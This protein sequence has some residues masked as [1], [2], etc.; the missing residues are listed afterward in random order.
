V[1]QNRIEKVGVA[2]FYGDLR[3]SWGQNELHTGIDVQ[4]NDVKSSA[5]S[6]NINTGATGKLDTRYPEKNTYNSFGIY[7]Q[8]LYKFK[9]KKWILND[10][11]RV[12]ATK[13]KSTVVEKSTAFARCH[14]RKQSPTSEEYNQ[15]LVF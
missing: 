5:Y 9:N 10:G 1:R 13:L 12:T 8:H 11:I 3:K 4:L 6:L 15:C 14:K 7:A 2:G